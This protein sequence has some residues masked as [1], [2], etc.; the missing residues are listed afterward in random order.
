MVKKMNHY[1]KD[2]VI[3]LNEY[4]HMYLTS[5]WFYRHQVYEVPGILTALLITYDDIDEDI[6]EL[7][8]DTNWE[9]FLERMSKV[10][11]DWS[12]ISKETMEAL[13]EQP[14]KTMAGWEGRTIYF[15][16]GGNNPEYWASDKAFEDAKKVLLSS[17]QIHGPLILD[18]AE[19]IDGLI[20]RGKKSYLDYENF[21]RVCINYIFSG[22]LAETKAQSRTEPG[23]EGVE[24]RDLLAHNIADAGFFHDLKNKYSCSEILFD[25]KNKDEI[26]RNDLRQIYCYLK[27]AIGLWGFIVCRTEQPKKINLYNRTL[28]QNFTQNRGVLILNDSDLRKMIKMRLRG[29]DPSE[30]M[31]KL[32]SSFL[33]SLHHN[34]PRR[35]Y[36]LLGAVDQ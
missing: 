31:Q 22:Q 15:I 2:Y 17:F 19:N 1:T 18:E 27:P 33:R 35:L 7:Y 34:L 10:K 20:P 30:H 6:F 32:M 36:L 26:S 11:S 13:A 16:R 9:K 25:S 5:T 12:S 21:V 28:F 14:H 3:A 29:H 4:L 24:I 8:D 23:N